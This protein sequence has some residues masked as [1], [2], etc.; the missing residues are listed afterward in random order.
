MNEASSYAWSRDLWTPPYSQEWS[1]RFAQVEII[2]DFWFGSF[3]IVV[4]GEIVQMIIG[5]NVLNF[6]PKLLLEVGN[7]RNSGQVNLQNSRKIDSRAQLKDLD[8]YYHYLC[9][10]FFGRQLIE[11]VFLNVFSHLLNL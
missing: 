4:L 6:R 7:F 3:K 1:S 11:M 10:Y 8:T 9:H 5:I 2:P